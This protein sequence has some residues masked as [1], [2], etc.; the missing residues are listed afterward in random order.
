MR[1]LAIL[2]LLLTACGTAQ[3]LPP[4]QTVTITKTVPVYPPD[5]LYAEKSGCV[6]VPKLK[7]GTVRDALN[8]SISKDAALA[9]CLGDRA[10]LRQWE[11]DNKKGNK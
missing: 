9:V 5:S 1:Y 3:N 6:A 4:P 10:A 7:A 2:A 8:S 11:L